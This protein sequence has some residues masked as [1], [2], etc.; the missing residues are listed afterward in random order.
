VLLYTFALK[1]VYLST[2]RIPANLVHGTF[3]SNQTSALDDLSDGHAENN[4]LLPD[5][6][7]CGKQ[8]KSDKLISQSL[9]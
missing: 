3:L 9:D 8:V 1:L 4:F 7:Q 5:C 6:K 2:P